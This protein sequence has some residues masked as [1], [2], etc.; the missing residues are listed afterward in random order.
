MNNNCQEYDFSMESLLLHCNKPFHFCL[1]DIDTQIYI[2][3]DH[4]LKK[5]HID[6]H[7]LNFA[8]Y[9]VMSG[10]QTKYQNK[11]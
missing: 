8:S 4:L 2:P 10:I 5:R 6:E 11:V 9:S 7:E 3:S 1:K